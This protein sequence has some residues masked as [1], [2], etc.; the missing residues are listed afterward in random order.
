MVPP[1]PSVP[2]QSCLFPQ[3]RLLFTQPKIPELSFQ[4]NILKSHLAAS[5]VWK[6]QLMGAKVATSGKYNVGTAKVAAMPEGKK[7][8]LLFTCPLLPLQ[9]CPPSCRR[10]CRRQYRAPPHQECIAP[11]A[12]CAAAVRWSHA[13]RT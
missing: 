11:Y 7:V 6:A 1:Y 4:P 3:G 12:T 10:T 13:M 5:Q 8:R 9:N 2:A